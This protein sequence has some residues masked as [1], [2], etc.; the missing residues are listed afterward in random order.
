MM[1][2][3]V[4]VQAAVLRA[5]LDSGLTHNFVDSEAA[6]RVGIKF[7]SRAG[8]SVAVTNGDRVASS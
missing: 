7:S 3:Y 1:Q 8:F 5:L 2:V 4:T 6:A